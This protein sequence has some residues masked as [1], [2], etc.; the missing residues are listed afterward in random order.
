MFYT[1]TFFLIGGFVTLVVMKMKS[2]GSSRGF[3]AERRRKAAH[4]TIKRVM[5]THMQTVTLVLGLAIPWPR[6]MLDTLSVVSSISSFSENVN[7]LECLYTG[8]RVGARHATFYYALLTVMALLPLGLLGALA[9]FWFGV[10]PKC[11]GGRYTGGDTTPN[12]DNDNNKDNDRSNI[13]CCGVAMVHRHRAMAQFSNTARFLPS[14]TD[15]FISS[16][17]LLWFLLL[18]SLVRIGFAV[19][20]CRYVGKP[21]PEKPTYLLVSMEEQCWVGRHVWFAV[22]V[23]LPMLALYALA[24]PI[25]IILRLRRARAG[26]DVDLKNPS[27]MLRF[28]LFFSGYRSERYWWE[29]SVL[30][31]KYAIISVSTFVA[32]ELNQLQL[33]LASL[34]VSM[35]LHHSQTPS[36]TGTRKSDLLHR[37]EMVSMLLLIFLAWCGVYFSLTSDLCATTHGTGWCAFLAVVLILVNVFYVLSLAGRCCLSWYKRSD[38]HVT[39][40]TQ[41]LPKLPSFRKRLVALSSVRSFTRSSGRMSGGEAKMNSSTNKDKEHGHSLSM[42]AVDLNAHDTS[43]ELVANPYEGMEDEQGN[44]KSRRV[45]HFQM[46][47]NPMQTRNQQVAAYGYTPDSDDELELMEG[48]IINAVRDEG[49]G[50]SH[51]RNFRTGLAGYFPTSWAE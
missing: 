37:S 16:G 29:L 1:G 44:M 36:G 27:L 33:V 13:K 7:S 34:I 38:A 46:S 14:T 11:C 3:N 32:S 47:M 28:G 9:L 42:S 18:P 19:F 49:N 6:L 17:V 23:G 2:F 41:V 21:K 45:T 35:Q 43:I 31:R 39:I 50:W 5:L 48:D 20:E 24:V 8:A 25:S 10:L 15:M 12:E 40:I 26:G 22:G 30:A 51:G 4:S